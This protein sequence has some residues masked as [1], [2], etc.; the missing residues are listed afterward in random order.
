[1]KAP[2]LTD[3]LRAM[4]AALPEGLAGTRDRA[5]LLV[6]FAGGFCRSELVAMDLEHVGFTQEGL[7]A[8]LPRSKT[9]QEGEGRVVGIVATRRPTCPVAA[10][11]AWIEATRIEAGPLWCPL[12][13]GGRVRAGRLSGYSVALIV[14]RAA[15]RAGY[16]AARFAGHS[17]RARMVTQA[18]ANGASEADIMRQTGHRSSKTLGRY[19]REGRLF[20]QNA[21]GRLGL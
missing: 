11:R 1:M 2:A 13:R 18:F 21:S 14:K 6:G 17:L 10:L 3:D 5:L 20:H 8:G 12:T 15:R 16:D 4:L 19:N 7:R 9:D